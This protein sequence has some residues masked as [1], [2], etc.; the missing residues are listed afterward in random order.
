MTSNVEL[1]GKKIKTVIITILHIFLNEERLY[2]LRRDIVNITNYPNW[3][4]KD[5][6]SVT[7]ERISDRLN[8]VGEKISGLGGIATENI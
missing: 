8:I 6:N 2:M 3:T 4:F 7:L 1:V 5:E